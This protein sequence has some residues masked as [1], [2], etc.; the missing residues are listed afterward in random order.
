MPRETPG[1]EEE[2]TSAPRGASSKFYS[3]DISAK[4]G[5]S[6]IAWATLRVGPHAI[7]LT[8]P[9]DAPDGT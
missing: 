4:S 6:W 9:A 8:A 7:G 3:L 2:A 1:P 5:E